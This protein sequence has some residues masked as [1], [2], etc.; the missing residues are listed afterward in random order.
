MH[1]VSEASSDRGYYFSTD[2]NPLKVS[3]GVVPE[4]KKPYELNP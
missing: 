1:T 3:E 2:E 4:E